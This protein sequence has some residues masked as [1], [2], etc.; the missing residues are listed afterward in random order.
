MHQ[1]VRQRWAPPLRFSLALGI[2]ITIGG[3]L[4]RAK[5]PQNNE[6]PLTVRVKGLGAERTVTMGAP[7]ELKLDGKTHLVTLELLP[8]RRLCVPDAC[9]EYPSQFTF[10][11]DPSGGSKTWTLSGNDLTVIVQ[12]NSVSV[13]FEEFAQSLASNLAA[14]GDGTIEWEQAPPLSVS[15]LN[16]A[17]RRMIIPWGKVEFRNNVYAL[18][19]RKK[20]KQARTFI[21]LQEVCDHDEETSQE[22][23]DCLELLG[24][25]LSPND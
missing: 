18:L 6:P 7:F 10:E 19:T 3:A 9:F 17:G 8:T 12:S 5:N 14:V 24:E 16:I 1:P 22:V 21:M 25:S 23:L 2:L 4:P 15:G 13:S 20:G 11:F